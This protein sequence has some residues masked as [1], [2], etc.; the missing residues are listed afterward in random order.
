MPERTQLTDAEREQRRAA[1][2]AFVQ[3]AVD[4]LRSSEGWQRWLTTRRH[5][6]SYSLLVSRAE[7]RRRLMTRS[8]CRRH[9]VEGLGWWTG[10]VPARAAPDG[11]SPSACGGGGDGPRRAGPDARRR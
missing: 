10:P 8:G 4:A 9:V 1:D 3:Q 2:R 11:G 6:H 7:R 5:F